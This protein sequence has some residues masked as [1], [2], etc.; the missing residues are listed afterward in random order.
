MRWVRWRTRRLERAN[1][2]SKN[3]VYAIPHAEF[4]F[5]NDLLWARRLLFADMGLSLSLAGSALDRLAA[6]YNRLRA[7]SSL[8]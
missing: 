4:R 5:L 1:A 2:G 7:L 6:L 3:S 8:R